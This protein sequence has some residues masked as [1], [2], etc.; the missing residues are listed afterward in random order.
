MGL[1]IV[2][3]AGVRLI[4]A[5][6]PRCK[7]VFKDDCRLVGVLI[8]DLVHPFA[9]GLVDEF[10]SVFPFCWLVGF[11]AAEMKKS[12]RQDLRDEYTFAVPPGFTYGKRRTVYALDTDNG[13]NR[14]VLLTHLGFLR[15]VRREFLRRDEFSPIAL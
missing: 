12:R 1:T 13:A 11:F 2:P 7:V 15:Q 14:A 9:D 8:G 10:H 5:T 4:L 3:K 6:S